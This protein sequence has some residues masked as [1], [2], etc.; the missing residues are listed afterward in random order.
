MQ[1]R[2]EIVWKRSSYSQGGGEQCVKVGTNQPGVVPIGDTKD[3]EDRYFTVQQPVF[4]A[5]VDAIKREQL[6]A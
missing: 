4:G 1:A 5:F 6:R 3:P 2:P